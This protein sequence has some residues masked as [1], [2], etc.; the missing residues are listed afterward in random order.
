MS[1]DNWDTCPRCRKRLLAE[2][3]AKVRAVV[4]S[5][6]KVPPETYMAD[7]QAVQK[8]P[9]P[10]ASL[11]EDYQLGVNDDG[12]FYVVYRCRCEHCDF[13]HEFKHEQQ[14]KT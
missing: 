13:R 4:A 1:A 6:G 11:R 10:P 7:F 8:Q 12:L 5:Y 9:Q 14:L 2:H 3:E